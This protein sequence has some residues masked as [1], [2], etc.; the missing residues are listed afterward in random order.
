MVKMIMQ[1]KPAAIAPT[2]HRTRRTMTEP[3]KH[4]YRRRRVLRA[5]SACARLKKK[6][7]HDQVDRQKCPVNLLERTINAFEDLPGEGASLAMR[8]RKPTKRSSNKP[9]KYVVAKAGGLS[10]DKSLGTSPTVQEDSE[11]PEDDRPQ[12]GSSPNYTTLRLHKP[13]SPEDLAIMIF[14][15]NVR[16][17]GV[18]DAWFGDAPYRI[19]HDSCYDLAMNALAMAWWYRRKLPGTTLAKVYRAMGISLDAL[20]KTTSK[21]GAILDDHI[22][23]SIAALS[24]TDAITSGHSFPVS[25]H[26]DG[27]AVILSSQATVTSLSSM[28]RRILEYHFCD[29]YVL[30]TVRGA[31]SRFEAMVSSY[32]ECIDVCK[33]AAERNLRAIGNKLCVHLPRLIGLV[34]LASGFHLSGSSVS[35]ALNLSDKLLQFQDQ[36]AE[37]EFLHTVGVALTQLPQDR[38]VTEYS[39]T[40]KSLSGFEAGLYYWHSRATL[41][42]LCSQL[43]SSFPTLCD[44]YA[45][46]SLQELQAESQRYASNILMSVQYARTNPSRKR[47][48]LLGQSLLACYNTVQDSPDTLPS[49]CDA[50][51]VRAWLLENWSIALLGQPSS[52]MANDMNEAAELFKGGPLVG[53]YK[54]LYDQMYVH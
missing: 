4:E 47:K 20:N 30:A 11:E 21:D 32:C 7:T 24:V 39:L 17:A 8:P 1:S 10:G 51:E 6:C 40:F 19:G 44:L 13:Q 46:P 27:V 31:A 52:L 22:L 50:D 45:L 35:S 18:A 9:Y 28:A 15:D 48:R 2:R 54:D 42:G 29:T 12:T 34:R 41:L 33:P 3:E 16:W 14:A 25:G 53:R 36:S 38:K 43:R 26:L 5:C 49:A 23:G 37:S